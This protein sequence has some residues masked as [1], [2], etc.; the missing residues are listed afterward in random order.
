MNSPAFVVCESLRSSS[1][2]LCVPVMGDEI[3]YC[4]Y[5]WQSGRDIQRNIG[6][7]M[8]RLIDF[9]LEDARFENGIVIEIIHHRQGLIVGIGIGILWRATKD[10]VEHWTLAI[11]E[12]RLGP[13]RGRAVISA[14]RSHGISWV[15]ICHQVGG[16]NFA[17]T[18]P[19]HPL[20]RQ[21]KLLQILAQISPS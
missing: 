6:G 7:R 5:H 2:N 3:C 19:V 12:E 13:G 9:V 8:V 1:A 11:V 14:V 16:Q 17:P 20:Q 15:P 21:F 18:R 10:I 4:R